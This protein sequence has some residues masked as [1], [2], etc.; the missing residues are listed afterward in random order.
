MPK[1]PMP[2]EFYDEHTNMKN[3]KMVMKDVWQCQADVPGMI[4]DLENHFDFDYLP[5]EIARNLKNAIN[6]LRTA[7]DELKVWWKGAKWA[8]Y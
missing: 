6:S 1:K 8:D 2:K 3:F 5:K 7:G 4:S